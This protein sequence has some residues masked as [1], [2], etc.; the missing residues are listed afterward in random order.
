MPFSSKLRA[1]TGGQ[2]D[3]QCGPI[4]RPYNAREG[5]DNVYGQSKRTTCGT[6]FE[7]FRAAFCHELIGLGFVLVVQCVQMKTGLLQHVTSPDSF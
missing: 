6:D 4:G 1:R 2:A 5:K 3:P 7:V